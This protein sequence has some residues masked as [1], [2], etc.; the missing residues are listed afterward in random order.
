MKNL[1]RLGL[2]LALTLVLGLSAS[3]GYAQAPCVPGETQSPP[4]ACA[5]GETSGPPCT[6]APATLDDPAAP[7]E[8]NTPPATNA[9]DVFSI[10]EFTV[11]LLLGWLF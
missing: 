4:C 9:V 5:P 7:G 1:R 10:S 6:S 8:T 3:A 2:T 11:D